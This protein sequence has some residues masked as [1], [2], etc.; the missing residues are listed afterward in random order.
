MTVTD[1][2]FMIVLAQAVREEDL[3]RAQARRASLAA[4][5]AG[6]AGGAPAAHRRQRRMRWHAGRALV[7]LGGRLLEP[8]RA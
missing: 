1:P 2:T 3:R 8:A 4:R 6:A 5:Q 7:A